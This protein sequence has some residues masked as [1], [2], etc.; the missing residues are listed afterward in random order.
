MKQPLVKHLAIALLAAVIAALV[1][2]G[3]ATAVID[4]ADPPRSRGGVPRHLLT[5]DE[6]PRALAGTAALVAFVAAWKFQR[7][8]ANR[9]PRPF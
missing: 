6:M 9:T 1:A 2:Y 3:I 5:A 8:L 7:W 4:P